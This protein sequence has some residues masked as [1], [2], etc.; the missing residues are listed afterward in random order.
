MDPFSDQY[1]SITIQEPEH[2]VRKLVLQYLLHN[3]YGDSAK[4]FLS[5]ISGM[6]P[7]IDRAN[8]NVKKHIELYTTMRAE[9]ISASTSHL[10]TAE[11]SFTSS[12]MDNMDLDRSSHASVELDVEMEE[13]QDADRSKSNATQKDRSDSLSLASTHEDGKLQENGLFVDIAPTLNE[14]TVGN[15][16]GNRLDWEALLNLAEKEKMNKEE[17]LPEHWESLEV[18]KRGYYS[19]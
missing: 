17:L 4:A 3:C 13:T 19:A 12:A 5:D 11:C 18:R 14:N 1:N 7:S 6:Q 8:G 15:S 16:N 9:K 2:T 10:T